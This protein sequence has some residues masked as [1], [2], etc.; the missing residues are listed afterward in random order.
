MKIILFFYQVLKFMI[1][2]GY[3]GSRDLPSANL[4][5]KPTCTYVPNSSYSTHR[6]FSSIFPY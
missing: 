1:T 2:V 6:A 3:S 4:Q 5:T